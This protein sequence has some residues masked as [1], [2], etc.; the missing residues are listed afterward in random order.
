[1]DN[2][3]NHNIAPTPEEPATLIVT[4][5]PAR[6]FH[7]QTHHFKIHGTDGRYLET[8]SKAI[9]NETIENNVFRLREQLCL[10]SRLLGDINDT[11]N[12]P[13]P[14]VLGMAELFCQVQ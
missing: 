2:M 4:L 11:V 1:M 9:T 13:A 6:Y 3:D 7:Y 8:I 14:A 12:L 5:N 10:V